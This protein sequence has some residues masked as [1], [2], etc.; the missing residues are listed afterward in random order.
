MRGYLPVHMQ[1]MER[2]GGRA[3]LLRF[4][5]VFDF[6]QNYEPFENKVCKCFIERPWSFVFH[7]V[8]VSSERQKIVIILEM[9]F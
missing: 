9:D 4:L 8:H 6:Y 7:R 5:Q 1:S 2:S 3:V